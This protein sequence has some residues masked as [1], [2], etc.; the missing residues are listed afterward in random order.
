MSGSNKAYDTGPDS[1]LPSTS[2]IKT[3]SD[4]PIPYEKD[5]ETQSIPSNEHKQ[6]R[7]QFIFLF[8]G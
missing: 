4:I 5:P 1:S 8:L 7:I 2:D 3:I 6:G